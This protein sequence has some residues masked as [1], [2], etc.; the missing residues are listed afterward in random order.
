MKPYEEPSIEVVDFVNDV[1]TDSN[2]SGGGG[3][4]DPDGNGGECDPNTSVP[5]IDFPD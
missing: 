3:V 4:P 2:L 1:I 5:C